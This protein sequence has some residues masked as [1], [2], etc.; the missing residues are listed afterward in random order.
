MFILLFCSLCTDP[1]PPA[2]HPSLPSGKIGEGEVGSVYRLTIFTLYNFNLCPV[3]FS[4]RCIQEELGFRGTRW[5]TNPIR[6]FSRCRVGSFT[7]RTE[8]SRYA[9]HRRIIHTFHSFLKL[10]NTL[11]QFITRLYG[12][13][14]TCCRSLISCRRLSSLLLVCCSPRRRLVWRSLIYWKNDNKINL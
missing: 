4:G 1:P 5:R 12:T 6:H 7:P 10:A 9:Q 3:I 2:P 13:W 11:Y 8:M 14:H